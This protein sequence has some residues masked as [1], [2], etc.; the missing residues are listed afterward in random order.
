MTPKDRK[1]NKR[2]SKS[3]PLMNKSNN[4]EN[5]NKNKDKK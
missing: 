3:K 5:E 1:N 2:C 4:K